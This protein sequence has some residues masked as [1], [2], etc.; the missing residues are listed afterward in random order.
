MLKD[1]ETPGVVDNYTIRAELEGHAPAVREL[2]DRMG[3]SWMPDKVTMAL[4]PLATAVMAQTVPPG[5]GARP[6][7]GA[8]SAPS[9]SEPARIVTVPAHDDWVA[10]GIV[11]EPGRTY[12]V[13][14]IGSWNMGGLCATTDPD[15]AGL[16]ITLFCFGEG[17]MPSANFSTLIGRIGEDGSPF[18]VGAGFDLRPDRRG[19][20]FLRSNSRIL[21]D[22]TGEVMV[23]I[24]LAAPP[25]PATAPV[26]APAR[27]QPAGPAG[28][29]AHEPVEV[30]FR[31]GPE[32]P[33]DIAVIVGNANYTRQGRDVPDVRPAYADA[34]GMRRY[35]IQTLGIRDGKV[36]FLRDA[37]GAQMVRVFSSD[38]DHRG[39]LFDWMRPN[40]S[41]VFVYY[42]GHGAPGSAGGGPYLVPADA[43]SARI[44]LNGYPLATLYD[45]LAKIPAESV[46]VVIEACFSGLS[47]A[48]SVL[49]KASPVFRD[50]SAPLVPPKLTVITAGSAGQVASWEEDGS[51]SLFT[52]YFLKGMAGEAD[53]APYGD[54]DGT[55]ALDEV[56]RYLKDTLTCYARRYYGRDQTAQI[57]RGVGQ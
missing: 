41:R 34:E 20:L 53:R 45:N 33:E 5:P 55:V 10:S 25:A 27:V 56:D 51:L 35:A 32:R 2:H 50:V 57:V 16:R 26:A 8:S 30:A 52:E 49:G 44:E 28:A 18:R 15:G 17:L 38:R 3:T 13:R 46:T 12:G 22:N 11:V 9:A 1:D 4:T 42:T 14:A 48:G 24:V 37:T 31:R 23:T 43:D 40:R 6:S 47:Q 36:I 19:M 29:F 7:A 39:Q 21:G 54:G